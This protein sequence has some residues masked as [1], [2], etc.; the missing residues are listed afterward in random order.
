M[1]DVPSPEEMERRR[2]EHDGCGCVCHAD[3][4][5][6]ACP[7]PGGGCWRNHAGAPDPSTVCVLGCRDRS[8]TIWPRPPRPRADGLLTCRPCADGFI[9]KTIDDEWR[10]GLLDELLE[11]AAVVALYLQP[12]SRVLDPSGRSQGRRRPA[13]PAP[14]SVPVASLSDIRARTDQPQPTPGNVIAFLDS[15]ADRIRLGRQLG[16]GQ[17]QRVLVI[18]RVL[19][20][21]RSSV[22]RRALRQVTERRCGGQLTWRRAVVRWPLDAAW[23]V[24]LTQCT[25]CGDRRPVAVDDEE[26]TAESKTVMTAVRHLD[27]HN[28]WVCAQPWVRDYA[29][30]LRS[31]LAELRAASGMTRPKRI[32][33]CPN[34]VDDRKGTVCGAVLNADPEADGTTCRACGREYTRREYRHLGRLIGQTPTKNAS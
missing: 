31:M 1:Q 33:T 11:L 15:W 6:S 28:E 17:C 7:I 29:A 14:L 8:S 13:S 23:P 22:R 34:V 25:S 10:P 5:H 12:G 2:A 16:P 24:L 3:V 4:A 21:L 18:G 27:R 32:G 20:P 30:G 26:S 9:G 19:Q